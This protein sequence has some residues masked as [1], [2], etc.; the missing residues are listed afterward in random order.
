VGVIGRVKM[1]VFG[2]RG[3]EATYLRGR[4]RADF[5]CESNLTNKK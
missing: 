4:E 3:L 2:V 1:D 5:D